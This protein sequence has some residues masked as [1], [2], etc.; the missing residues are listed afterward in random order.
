MRLWNPSR[1]SPQSSVRTTDL[2]S[3]PSSELT[4]YE[5]I[6]SKEQRAERQRER[7]TRDAR[8]APIAARSPRRHQ[9]PPYQAPARGSRSYKRPRLD[10]AGNEIPTINEPSGYSPSNH[11]QGTP[12]RPAPRSPRDRRDSH[13]HHAALPPRPE[14]YQNRHDAQM[15]VDNQSSRR[16]AP[17]SRPTYNNRDGNKERDRGWD[18]R[19]NHG[20]NGDRLRNRERERDSGV[21]DDPGPR[22]V[23]TR[24]DYRSAP[25]KKIDRGPPPRSSNGSNGSYQ[26]GQNRGLAERMGL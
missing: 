14:P 17:M 2:I 11:R 3:N 10:N 21:N 15:D 1:E 8:D 20:R 5:E 6:L 12:P 18:N 26:R 22:D 23:E 9:T 25:P 13:Q 19:S 16:H 7:E 24:S 4:H